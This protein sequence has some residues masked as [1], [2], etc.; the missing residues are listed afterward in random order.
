MKPIVQTLALITGLTL[1]ISA[2]AE[3]IT[4]KLYAYG[5][6]A[7]TIIVNGNETASAYAV[8]GV[9]EIGRAHV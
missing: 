4:L 8:K 5:I 2:Q 1:P 6:K 7:G 9:L 3:N